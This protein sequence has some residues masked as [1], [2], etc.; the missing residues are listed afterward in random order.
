MFL[1]YLYA[2]LNLKKNRGTAN[3]NH[4]HYLLYL[5]LN[6]KLLKY[7]ARDEILKKYATKQK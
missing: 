1:F 4:E 6:F 5:L 2:A 3:S 7:D